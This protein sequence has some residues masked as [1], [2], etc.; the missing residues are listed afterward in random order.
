MSAPASCG[1]QRVLCAARQVVLEDGQGDLG[2]L[3]GM[4]RVLAAHHAL[5]LGELADHAGL[6]VGLAQRG[7]ALDGGADAERGRSSSASAAA[8][9][10][11]RSVFSAMVP[12]AAEP[13]AAMEPGGPVGQRRA[14]V[15]VEEEAAVGEAG[16]EHALVAPTDSSSSFTGV[17]DTAMN[18]GTSFPSSPMSEK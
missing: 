5:Q 1:G 4:E 17:F 11:M 2:R 6:E 12:R 7:R 10:R 9:A 8:S 3:L 15:F 13:G 18:L 16:A 14:A